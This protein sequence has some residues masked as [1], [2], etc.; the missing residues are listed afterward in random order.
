MSE[1]ANFNDWALVAEKKGRKQ[2][3]EIL[4]KRH[5]DYVFRLALGFSG[6]RW[7]A[8]DVVQEVFIRLYRKTFGDEHRAAFTTYL[9]RFTLNV[10]REE[11]RGYQMKKDAMALHNPWDTGDE[12][13]EARIKDIEKALKGLSQK[14]REVLTLR[15]F[16]EKSVKETA[17]IMGCKEG[18]VKSNLHWAIN[19]LKKLLKN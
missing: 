1:F 2:A 7:I 8:D 3:F 11:L 19:N 5:R 18:T 4:F 16:E 15:F 9:Y 14:Q 17:D 6:K 13:Q 10:T 12:E